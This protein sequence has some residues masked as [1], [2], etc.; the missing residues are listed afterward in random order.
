MT[1]LDGGHGVVPRSA[2]D[3]KSNPTDETS[4]SRVLMLEVAGRLAQSRGVD[5]GEDRKDG[6]ANTVILRR[7]LKATVVF[8]VNSEGRERRV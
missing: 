4:G 7:G 8:F 1:I 5:G 6:A 2:F 3:A